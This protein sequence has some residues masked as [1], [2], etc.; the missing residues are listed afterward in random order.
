MSNRKFPPAP[1]SVSV[2]F[3]AAA[4]RYVE[5]LIPTGLYGDTQA[6]VVAALAMAHLRE[7]VSSGVL[8]SIINESSHTQE[9]LHE[10]I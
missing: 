2:Q 9:Y 3:P 5:M 7:S 10:P 4:M 6:E 1:V 8:A